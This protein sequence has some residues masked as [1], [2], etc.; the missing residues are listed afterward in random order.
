MFISRP[1][2]LAALS[3]ILLF[4]AGCGGGGSSA[5]TNHSGDGGSGSPNESDGGTGGGGSDTDAGDGSDSDSGGG[6]DSGDS[7]ADDGMSGLSAHDR[8]A[9]R[10][11][12]VGKTFALR[13]E[14]ITATLNAMGDPL[15][16]NAPDFCD[17]PNGT[18]MLDI[19]QWQP[20][21]SLFEG[22][23]NTYDVAALDLDD[24]AHEE[25]LVTG[26]VL[27]ATGEDQGFARGSGLASGRPAAPLYFF[28]FGK[29]RNQPLRVEDEDGFHELYALVFN[30]TH[31]S[32]A[33]QERGKLDYWFTDGD[34]ERSQRIEGYMGL[35]WYT[36]RINPNNMLRGGARVTVSR[37]DASGAERCPA[38]GRSD[39]RI[40]RPV[41]FAGADGRI[42]AESGAGRLTSAEGLATVT[43]DGVDR[44]TVTLDDVAESY[45]P[46]AVEQLRNT[47]R[48]ECLGEDAP[49]Q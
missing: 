4:L 36:L 29:D 21:G 20:G 49:A 28:R 33:R 35:P 12:L 19:R 14:A 8:V 34:T 25:R 15:H 5:G 22:K 41:T 38:A 32:G 47:V 37:T 13:D 6:D 40:T 17:N 18:A 10:Y 42:V 3:I 27:Y 2:R 9:A 24:C 16:F 48:A 43:L 7:D 26:S 31:R 44:F 23:L 30:S 1:G 45:D 46:V 39:F 11:L